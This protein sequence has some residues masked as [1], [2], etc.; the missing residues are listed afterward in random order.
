MNLWQDFTDNLP[1][2]YHMLRYE[3]L[4]E[5]VEGEVRN[6]LDF[7]QLEWSEEVLDHVGNAQKHGIIG[8]PSY[9]Q[10]TQPIYKTARYRW[11]RYE[12]QLEPYMETLCPFIEKFG[13]R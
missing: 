6:L 2:K 4:I 7:L 9:H 8:T 10:V 11:K 1:L 5:N 13:Y 3:D 12:S